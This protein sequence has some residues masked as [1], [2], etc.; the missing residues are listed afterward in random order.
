MLAG[1]CGKE[2]KGRL[3]LCS[4][5]PQGLMERVTILHER[6]REIPWASVSERFGDR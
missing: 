1:L 3:P 2:K 5:V 6:I 4:E